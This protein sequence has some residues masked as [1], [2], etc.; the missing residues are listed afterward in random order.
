MEYV[1]LW[2]FCFIVSFCVLFVCKC[3]L[4]CCHR[5]STQL[6]LTK[7]VSLEILGYFPT[8][9]MDV[10]TDWQIPHTRSIQM[11]IKKVHKSPKRGG[12]VSNWLTETWRRR[13]VMVK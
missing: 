2:V 5:V 12:S 13:I 6:Q 7:Y 4:Y 1:Q 10:L 11:Y 8:Q 3:V 9:D